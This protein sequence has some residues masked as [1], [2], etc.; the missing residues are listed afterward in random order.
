M[1]THIVLRADIES[2]KNTKILISAS[3]FYQLFVNDRFVAFGPCRAAGGYARIDEIALEKYHLDGGN[4]VRIEVAGYA[5]HSLSTVYASSFVC[6]EITHGGDILLYTGRDFDCYRSAYYEQKTERYSAQRHFT[7]VYDAREKEPF[8]EV[9]A[10]RT[11]IVKAP[12]WLERKASYPAYRDIKTGEAVTVGTYAFD[13]TLPY[14]KTRSSFPIDVSWGRYEEAEIPYKPYRWIQRQKQNPMQY[15]K[16]LPLTLHENEYAIFDL[17]RIESGFLKFSADVLEETDVVIGYTELSEPDHFEFTN[18]N[19]QNVLE[20]I[21]PVGKNEMMSFEPYT[22]RF[23]IMLVKKGA[24]SVEN[25]GILTLE[26]DMTGLIAREISDSEYRLIYD[27]AVNTFAHNASDI[28]MDCPSRERAGWLCDSYFTGI[29]EYFFLGKSDVEA[30]FLEN[31]RLYENDGSIPM[32]ALPM[33]YP[34]DMQ[35]DN[36]F[37]PQWN[38]WYVFEVRD[39]LLKRGHEAEKEDFRASVMGVIDFLRNYENADGLLEDLPSW[40]FVEWSRANDWTKNVN[41]PTNFLYVGVLFA[42]YEL[43]GDETLK[44]KAIAIREKTKKFA[45][46]D[47]KFIDNA[48]R[49][50]NGIL[51]NTENFS[52]AGQYYAMLFGDISLDEPI[53]KKWTIHIRNGFAAFADAP[54]FVPVN[55]FIGRYLRMQTLLMLEEYDILLE[56]IRTFFLGMAQTTGTLWEYKDGKG[57]KDHGF[58]SFA[59]VALVCALEKQKIL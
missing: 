47:E 30:A 31:F 10:I 56:N 21:L 55:A 16:A 34:S 8:S 5:C 2:L 20:Y 38:M 40:N 29:A 24:L 43:Y 59:A 17:N 45:F 19:C 15:H 36:K 37:I 41:Y 11:E 13:G 42:A 27:A 3:S 28:Y 14:F 48:I 44:E 23:A 7:E 46:D 52:E 51:K 6:A 39:F 54:D 53:Y 12:K 32:G 26:C 35:N 18:I 49:D 50:E 58:A 22:A 1:N 33:C 57:S 25:F 4:T 9:Y